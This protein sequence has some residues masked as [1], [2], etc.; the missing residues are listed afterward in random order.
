MTHAPKRRD[1]GGSCGSAT[2]PAVAFVP[3]AAGLGS[4]RAVGA[5][6]FEPVGAWVGHHRSG[7]Q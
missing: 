5:D 2:T 6:L 3:D 4:V 7:V 1:G